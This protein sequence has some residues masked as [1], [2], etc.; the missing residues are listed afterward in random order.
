MTDLP[1][2]VE[3]MLPQPDFDRFRV[4][5]KKNIHS[6]EFKKKLQELESVFIATMF[7]KM[8]ETNEEEDSPF[9]GGF[10]G[11]MY[12]SLLPK[13]VGDIIAKS[14]KLGIAKRMYDDL[15]RQ[16]Q[17]QKNLVNYSI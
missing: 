11:K 5:S 2:P 13:Y 16:D 7:E 8:M 15:A 14:G 10:D 17:A 4:S 6:P 1:A 9:G 12:A 3:P